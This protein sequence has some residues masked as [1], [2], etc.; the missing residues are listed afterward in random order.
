MFE[1]E[2][3]GRNGL[4]VSF[5]CFLIWKERN[6]LTRI[7]QQPAGIGILNSMHTGKQII[8]KKGL[9]SFHSIYLCTIQG[10]VKKT[11]DSSIKK[12]NAFSEKH[13]NI[14]LCHFPLPGELARVLNVKR[15]F[16][17]C[18]FALQMSFILGRT[19]RAGWH[20]HH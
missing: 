13:Q 18:C 4:E 9:L 6:S 3:Q 15:M 20:L 19:S 1:E 12:K 11:R 10:N 8:F 16:F 7:P 14:S 17:S 5:S 2:F